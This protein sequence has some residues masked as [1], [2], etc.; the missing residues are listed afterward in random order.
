MPAFA[1]ML[2]AARATWR[3][4]FNLDYGLTSA[5]MRLCGAI[6]FLSYIAFHFS[7]AAEGYRDWIPLRIGAVLLSLLIVVWP[8][9]GALGKWRPAFWEIAVDLLLPAGQIF[10]FL[11]NPPNAYW[12]TSNTFWALFLGLSTKPVWLPLHL[13]GGQALGWFGF[14]MVWRMA[15]SLKLQALLDGQ[16]IIWSTAFAGMGIKVGLEVFHRRGL[17]VAT[18]NARAQEAEAR[19]AELQAAYAEL[20]RRET[21]IK[22]FVRPSLFH[23][24]SQA[25][26]PTHFAPIQRELAVMFCD[27]RDFTRL[28]EVLSAAEKQD[29]LNRYFS[30]ITGPI[31]E[32]GGEVD[33]IMRDCVMSLFPDGRSAVEAAQGMRLRLQDFN[34]DFYEQGKPTIRNGI[35]IAKGEV[36]LG[37]FGS[38][39]KLDR[40]VIG[41]AVN[42]AARL[43]SKTKMYNLEVAVTDEIVRDMGPDARH[44]RWIDQVRVKGSSRCLKLHEF[45]GHQPEA[46]RRYKDES[47]GLMEQALNLYFHKGFRDAGR[48]FRSMYEQVPGHLLH[49]GEH[50]DDLLAYYIAHCEAWAKAAR[51]SCETIERWDGVHAFQ[52]K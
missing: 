9:S 20:E 10:L 34:R 24:L 11:M 47:R 30:L 28:T 21:V 48:M 1:R 16:T 14:D 35:G 51:E 23:E 31:L 45:Y 33:K 15:D 39:E 49:P 41:E 40:T 22:R 52:D 25:K 19:A 38:F 42:I 27:L 8:T 6:C 44:C 13:I 26:D 50:M 46:V 37:N 43:E 2:P 7:E 18:A 4:V 36:L 29:F 32:N 12:I 5:F 3:T 17:S